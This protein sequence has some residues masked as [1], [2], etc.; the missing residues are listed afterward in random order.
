MSSKRKAGKGDQRFAKRAKSSGI[1][2]FF[3]VSPRAA[4]PPNP[5][6]PVS[7]AQPP[8]LLSTQTISS[9]SEKSANTLTQSETSSQSPIIPEPLSQSAS[10]PPSL[11]DLNPNDSQ[12]I[13]CELKTFEFVI[14]CRPSLN[15]V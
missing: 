11:S 8:S 12:S 7:T 15:M 14:I 2:A 10:P 1:A 13:S 9:E 3:T 6:S 5:R 4:Y